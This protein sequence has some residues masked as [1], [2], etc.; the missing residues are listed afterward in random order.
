MKS[1][2]TFF[3]AIITIVSFNQSFGQE[4]V[5]SSGG[6][7]TGATGSVSY[8]VGQVFYTA[9]SSLGGSVSQGVQQ[10]Y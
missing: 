6:T 9:Q 2:T 3:I 5:N 7:A 8:S 4:S 10:A 1:I